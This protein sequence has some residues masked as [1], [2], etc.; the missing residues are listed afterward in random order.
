VCGSLG[1]STPMSHVGVQPLTTVGVIGLGTIAVTHIRVLR[2]LCPDIEVVGVDPQGSGA[3]AASLTDRV[4]TDLDTAAEA[5]SGAG[6]WVVATPTRAHLEA[7][8]QLLRDAPDARVL[9]EKPLV[10]S[11]EDLDLL[12]RQVPVSTLRSRLFVSHHFAF[13]PE[14]LWAGG[15]ASRL[16]PGELVRAT[17]VFHDPY[18][19]TPPQ[20]RRSYVDP[21]VDSGPNQLSVLMATSRRAVRVED[22]RVLADGLRAHA[23]GAV[24]RA[25]S[26]AAMTSWLAPDSSKKTTLE[27]EDG[28]RLWLDHTAVTGVA[29]RDDR[30]VEWFETDGLVP[31]KVLHYRALYQSLLSEDPARALRFDFAA[32]VVRGLSR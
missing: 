6:L 16:R 2:G 17:L 11:L 22:V 32:E 15:A 18:A 8:V 31:R 27:Y 24:G 14:V 7:T 13:S 19:A 25:G 3:R 1:R 5:R 4:Y 9:V 21:W 30:P 29:L 12:Q 26:F 10:S 20:D 28:T 23:T